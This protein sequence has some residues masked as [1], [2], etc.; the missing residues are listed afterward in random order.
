MLHQF[1]ILFISLPSD[2]C[3]FCIRDTTL[4]HSRPIDLI[5]ELHFLHDGTEQA[6]GIG[7]IVNGK[8][9]RITDMLRFIPQNTGK[10]GMERPHPQPAR[11]LF[12]RQ[13]GD[14]LFHLA[15]RLIG[16]CKCQNAPGRQSLL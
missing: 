6:F 4:Y 9:G 15:S 5:V 16:E 8:V 3:I 2:K 7:C 1:L 13:S 10:K 14:T 11:R 12:V